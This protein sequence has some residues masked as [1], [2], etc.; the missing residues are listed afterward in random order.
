MRRNDH[1]HGRVVRPLAVHASQPPTTDVDL[2][3][4]SIIER[5]GSAWPVIGWALFA[6]CFLS[7][8]FTNGQLASVLAVRA[9]FGIPLLLWWIIDCIDQQVALWQILIGAVMLGIGQLP[10]GGL[11]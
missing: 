4:D 1:K 3:P 7:P 6:G 11:L 9:G 5:M 8:Y 2:E 10:R